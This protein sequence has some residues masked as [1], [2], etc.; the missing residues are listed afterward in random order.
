[1]KQSIL[2]RVVIFLIL[3]FGLFYF[4]G[5]IGRKILYP[6]RLLVTFLHEFGHATGA[7]VSGGSVENLQINSDGSGYART[8]GGSRSIILMGGYL[9]SAIFGN[10]LFLVAARAKTFIQPTLVLLA[11]G[12]LYAGFFWFNS[13][14]T[15]GILIAFA[16]SIFLIIWKTNFER[17]VLMFF[18][19][20]SILFI[21]QDF[22][23]GPTS[24]LEKYAE[25]MVI[26]PAKAWMYIWLAVALFLFVWNMKII[27][28]ME[29]KGTA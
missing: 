11:C 29:K 6:V 25:I 5:S 20:A 22:N 19:L 15:T 28:S 10:L 24:D 3:Y 7:L 9:G 16:V 26:L 13:M 14:F 12:M 4:G 2:V 18:G 17:E 1:M 21:I 27:L 23:V 8:V